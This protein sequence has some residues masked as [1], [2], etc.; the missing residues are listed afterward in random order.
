MKIN[1][2]SKMTVADLRALLLG[3]DDAA[4]VEFT[5]T[6]KKDQTGTCWC[7]C[8]S[9]TKSKFAPGHDSRFHSLAKKVARGQED[10]Q[11]ALDGLAHDDARAEFQGC[12]DHETP[13][14]EARVA[15]AELIKASKPVKVPATKEPKVEVRSAAKNPAKPV[16]ASGMSDE[17]KAE[18]LR[19]VT[20][21]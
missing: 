10:S 12:V 14:H 5:K 6:L 16:T 15:A 8:G 9:S 20:M 13:L 7:G 1:T 17:D 18:L 19:K 2:S 4:T 21:S 3:A 11:E